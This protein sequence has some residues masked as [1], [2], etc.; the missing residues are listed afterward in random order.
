M[1]NKYTTALT[2]LKSNIKT[3]E[4]ETKIYTPSTNLYT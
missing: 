2:V 3:V 1:N 4:K